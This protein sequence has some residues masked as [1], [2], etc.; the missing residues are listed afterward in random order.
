ML[1]RVLLA[2]QKYDRTLGLVRMLRSDASN[3]RR[4]N[5]VI[6]LQALEALALA[7]GGDESAA[8]AIR[9]RRSASRSR[10]ATSV[11]SSTRAR[12]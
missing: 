12:R 3:Q 10:R 11:S 2:Q 5:S 6:E 7:A 1:V 8:L 9:P 4:T